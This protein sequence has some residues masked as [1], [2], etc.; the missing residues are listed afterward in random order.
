[1]PPA[2]AITDDRKVSGADP[3]AAEDQARVERRS[4][5]ALVR[6]ASI[7]TTT[8]D[9]SDLVEAVAET[10]RQLLDA[11]SLS[12]SELSECRT[13]LRTLINVG[14]LGSGEERWPTNESYLITD[15]PDT[16]GFLVDKPVRRLATH[17]D[18]PNAEPAEVKLLV[19]LGKQSSLKTP[20]VVDGRV[21]GEMWA[22]R[23]PGRPPFSDYDGD[24]AEVIVGLVSAGL[25]QAGAWQRMHTI[26]LTDP[27]TEVANRR[28]FDEHLRRHLARTQYSDRPL[29][30]VVADV[31]GLKGVN[32]SSGHAAGDDVL[33]Y[34]AAAARSAVHDV[35]DGLACRLGGDEFALLLP[36]VEL[37][38]AL[39]VAQSWCRSAVHPDHGTSL[40]CGVA[41]SLPGRPR[42]DPSGLLRLADAAQY[43]AKHSGSTEPVIAE[44]GR[45]GRHA[46]PGQ[47]SGSGLL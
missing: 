15:F 47:E 4:L 8:I 20:I 1:L 27:L 11:D 6:L 22:S 26:A 42:I 43:Q 37:D 33:I 17:V 23:G 28:G 24:V 14:D 44:Q 36:D 16:L 19:S 32:D 34:V 13:L 46:A 30:L 18:D 2:G 31:N 39:T 3:R 7:V 40:A 38:D 12:V 35:T 9:P 41:M 5:R 29:A 10:S 21:W 25:S 45:P